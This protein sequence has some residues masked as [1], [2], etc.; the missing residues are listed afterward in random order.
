[1]EYSEEADL[2]ILS[3]SHLY[4]GKYR[5]WNTRR[6]SAVIGPERYKSVRR[7]SHVV[8]PVWVN[9]EL[10]YHCKVKFLLSVTCVIY[11]LVAHYL[12]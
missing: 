5:V 3:R 1:M 2:Q 4:D 6:I 12:G 10:K 8:G 9:G 11:P 7:M